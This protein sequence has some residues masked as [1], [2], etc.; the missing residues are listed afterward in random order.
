MNTRQQPW[1]KE[2][3]ELWKDDLI[4]LTGTMKLIS[5]IFETGEDGLGDSPDNRKNDGTGCTVRLVAA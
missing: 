2:V 4:S 3:L 1:L 5:R